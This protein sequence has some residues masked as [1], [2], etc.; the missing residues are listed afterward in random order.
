MTKQDYRQIYKSLVGA[1]LS[2]EYRSR[3]SRFVV[4]AVRRLIRPEYRRIGLYMPMHDEP[5]LEPLLLELS[6]QYKVY[7]PRV[8]GERDM[9]FYAF[10]GLDALERIGKYQIL[11]PT[12]QESPVEPSL[13]DAIVVPAI[14]FDSLGFRLG[15]GKGYYDRYLTRTKARTI[16]VSLGLMN[17]EQLPRD[18]WDLPMDEVVRIEL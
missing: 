6:A 1:E 16:G 2:S 4:D 12:S 14:A 13:L 18:P 9:D 11:E 7:L 5:D 15:R 8:E 3:V 10:E 17:I